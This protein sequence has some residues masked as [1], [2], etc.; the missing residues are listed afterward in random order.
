[1]LALDLDPFSCFSAHDALDDGLWKLGY[2]STGTTNQC[3]SATKGH[4]VEFYLHLALKESPHIS[5]ETGG[6]LPAM[7]LN[8]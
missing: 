2:M 1:M 7:V 8:Q 6:V 5:A 4:Y 3:C